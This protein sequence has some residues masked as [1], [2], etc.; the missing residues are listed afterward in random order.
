MCGV[1]LRR[2]REAGD[3][4]ADFP[5]A[6]RRPVR[7]VPVVSGNSMEDTGVKGWLSRPGVAPEMQEM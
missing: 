3:T 7:G 6:A 4:E 5:V 1:S 2:M